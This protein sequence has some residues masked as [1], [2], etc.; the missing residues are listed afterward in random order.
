MTFMFYEWLWDKNKTDKIMV[1][2]GYSRVLKKED[3]KLFNITM[4]VC[5]SFAEF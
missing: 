1:C 5:M 2:L 4:G 3:G